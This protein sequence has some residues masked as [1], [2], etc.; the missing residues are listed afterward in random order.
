MT[1]LLAL[2]CMVVLAG[3]GGGS[4]GGNPLAQ[5]P[6]SAQNVADNSSDFPGLTK[7]P[8]SG[9]YDNYLKAEQTKAPDQYASDK[10]TWDDLKKSGANDS[11][12]AIYAANTS[13]CGQFGSGTPSGK[14]AYVYAFRFKDS[15]TAA[16]S[17]KADSKDFHLSDSDIA[18]LKA[19]GGTAQQGAATGLGDNSVVLSISIADVAVYVAFWQNKQFEVAMLAFNEPAIGAS[20]AT[21][22]N[23]RVH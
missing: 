4:G 3:C 13:D 16:A 21:K 22:I 8:E 12:V 17:F 5:G 18:S 9:S 6:A 11:Y 15:T 14:V 7:C 20:A 23:G 1:R 10:I 19:A 2:A